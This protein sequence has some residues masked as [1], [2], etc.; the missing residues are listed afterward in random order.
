MSIRQS[1]FCKR[2]DSALYHT[3]MSLSLENLQAFVKG[4]IEV[5]PLGIY[6]GQQVVMICNEEGKLRD[7]IRPSIAWT[8]P[9]RGILDIIFGDV[10]FCAQDGEALVGLYGRLKHFRAWL[11]A[12]GLRIN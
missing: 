9:G 7:D 10:V 12:Q 6:E 1:V 11:Q 5:V 2:E 4:Y 8:A 3:N